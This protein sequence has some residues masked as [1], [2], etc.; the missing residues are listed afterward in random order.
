[1]RFSVL[2]AVLVVLPQFTG[3]AQPAEPDIPHL[4]EMVNQ[5]EADQVRSD[6]PSLLSRYPNNP[7]ILYV[8]ALVSEEGT[9][10][11]RIYQSIVDNFPRSEW[12]DDAL[13]RVYQFYYALG[14]YRTAELKLSQLRT[15]YPDSPYVRA[16]TGTETTALEEERPTAEAPDSTATPS[17]A[18]AVPAPEPAAVGSEQ[19]FLQVGAFTVQANAERQKTAFAEWN[20]PVEIISRTKDGRS[21]F[22]VLVG[23]YATYEEAKAAGAEI[24]KAHGVESIVIAR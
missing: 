17:A 4:I 22:L 8:Q 3:I 12:A 19:Y 2:V 23:Q 9:E 21:L 14:L 15:E 24:K 11:V 5:G 1:M 20:Y 7:G 6:L 16:T 10:A 18:A 13:Y